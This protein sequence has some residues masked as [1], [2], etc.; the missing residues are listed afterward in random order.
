M[1]PLNLEDPEAGI[2][3]VWLCGCTQNGDTNRQNGSITVWSST[4]DARRD[5][6]NIPQPYDDPI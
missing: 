5:S 6:L 2:W 4:M 3:K 1:V